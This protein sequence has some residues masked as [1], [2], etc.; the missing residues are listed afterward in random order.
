MDSRHDIQLMTEAEKIEYYTG[1]SDKKF[2]FLRGVCSDNKH[3]N[4][5]KALG[6]A[7]ELHKGQ[8]RKSGEPYIIHPLSLACDAVGMHMRD[9]PLLAAAVLHDVLEDIGTP[10]M[11]LPVDD[12]TRVVVE[13]LTLRRLSGESK[14]ESKKRYY[15]NL[16]KSK[17]ATIIKGLDR[18]NNLGTMAKAL[19]RASIVKNCFETWFFIIPLLKDAKLNWPEYSNQLHTIR[20]DLTAL[21]DTLSVLVGIDL[22]Y[23]NPPSDDLMRAILSANSDDDLKKIP[24][25]F[26]AEKRF[27]PLFN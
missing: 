1:K 11:E 15:N 12:E 18:R 3:P 10:V 4:L 19:S 14:L 16:S 27:P 24:E 17:Y 5:A 23:K 9:D 2:T 21:V 8:T 26:N 20:T 6:C 22:S 13:Y 25:I 7:R